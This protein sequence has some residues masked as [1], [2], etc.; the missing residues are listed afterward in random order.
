MKKIILIVL[1]TA[2]VSPP[3][4]GQEKQFDLGKS[5][6]EI[7]NGTYSGPMLNNKLVEEFL[8]EYIL[9]AENYGLLMLPIIQKTLI[10]FLLN[11]L[12]VF[13]LS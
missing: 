10:S 9:E 3:I 5:L 6:S 7:D 13:L 12:Q 1:I 8:N 2:V 4:F 11:L